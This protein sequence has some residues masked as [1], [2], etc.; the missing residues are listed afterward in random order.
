MSRLLHIFIVTL[1][2][3]V[4]VAGEVAADD[5]DEP[6]PGCD[7]DLSPLVMSLNHSPEQRLQDIDNAIALLRQMGDTFG[8]HPAIYLAMGRLYAE[9]LSI[10]AMNACLDL[11]MWAY[12][13]SLFTTVFRDACPRE[14]FM[15]KGDSIKAGVREKIRTGGE[16]MPL[17]LHL[18]AA[19]IH[20]GNPPQTVRFRQSLTNLWRV[21]DRVGAMPEVFFYLG[22]AYRDLGV[23]DSMHMYFDSTL[24][25]C[26]DNSLYYSDRACCNRGRYVAV[27][28]SLRRS[29]VGD[30]PGTAEHMAEVFF[31][32]NFMDNINGW[33]VD[34]YGSTG[35]GIGKG[36]YALSRFS[37]GEFLAVK[38]AVPFDHRG[39]FVISTALAKSD[40]TDDN[41]YGL[42]WG[43]DARGNMYL[44]S[45]NGEGLF[46]VRKIENG[47]WSDVVS[48]QGSPLIKRGKSENRLSVK[49]DGVMTLF[50]INGLP[51]AA[52]PRLPLFGDV[53]G[54][55][56]T[57]DITFSVDY[58][59]VYRPFR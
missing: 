46:T 5:G 2:L 35:L 37:R 31:Y 8:P 47:E 36:R 4:P 49:Y 45:L 33:P 21:C 24:L 27:I 28:D 53:L 19:Y 55:H 7:I 59:L 54:F 18:Q 26:G 22:R 58:L 40:G 57:E 16:D 25:Y 43:G 14:Y 23:L 52:A 32:E 10:D 30:E 20:D 13:D 41:G 48:W 17:S 6:R 42:M 56:L 34:R 15:A 9:A 1:M 29:V 3:L 50:Y 51:V 39:D 12:D 44:F 11:V 38:K